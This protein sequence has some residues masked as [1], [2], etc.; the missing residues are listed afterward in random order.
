MG[1]CSRDDSVVTND[2]W[3]DISST[4]SMY[5]RT[6][7]TG[8]RHSIQ[9]LGTLLK[10][11]LV[12][13]VLRVDPSWISSTNSQMASAMAPTQSLLCRTAKVHPECLEMVITIESIV[14]DALASN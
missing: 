11:S 1:T 10:E 3:A 7:G 5:A 6:E 14:R 4:S 13:N 8:A 2:M 9:R 12:A